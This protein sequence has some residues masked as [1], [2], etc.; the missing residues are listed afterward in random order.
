MSHLQ[1]YRH[2]TKLRLFPFAKDLYLVI[3]KIFQTQVWLFFAIV[4]G[5]NCKWHLCLA[6]KLF[7]RI[8]LNVNDIQLQGLFEAQVFNGCHNKTNFYEKPNKQKKWRELTT[9]RW[10]ETYNV[11]WQGYG[12]ASCTVQKEMVLPCTKVIGHFNLCFTFDL[13]SYLHDTNLQIMSSRQYE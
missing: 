13:H 4:S 2:F 11:Q 6:H 1:S 3:L 5:I 10:D 7:H 12:N 9:N 8:P